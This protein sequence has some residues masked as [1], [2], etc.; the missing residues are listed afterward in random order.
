MLTYRGHIPPKKR[1]HAA[2]NAKKK[3]T[4]NVWE[5]CGRFCTHAARLR[6]SHAR[7]GSPAATGSPK[8]TASRDIGSGNLDAAA[9]FFLSFHVRLLSIE[10][11]H[12]LTLMFGLLL[13]LSCFFLF[14]VCVC[15]MCWWLF[16]CF[17]EDHFKTKKKKTGNHFLLTCLQASN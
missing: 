4:A 8:R 17:K 3:K 7:S 16:C 1:K 9:R 15:S 2:K 14:C 10:D 12:V 13:Q 5:V 6:G 11:E